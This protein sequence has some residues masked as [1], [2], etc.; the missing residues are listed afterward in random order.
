MRIFLHPVWLPI[1][2]GDSHKIIYPNPARK[3]NHQ[4]H[5]SLTHLSMITMPY[6]PHNKRKIFRNIRLPTL[7]L[8]DKSRKEAHAQIKSGHDKRREDQDVVGY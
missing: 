2:N 6:L 7:K 8:R 3:D 5:L 4:T 1:Y